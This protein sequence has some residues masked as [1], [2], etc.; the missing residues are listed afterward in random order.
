MREWVYTVSRYRLYI[1]LVLAVNIFDI[2][3]IGKIKL[4]IL[5]YTEFKKDF[6]NIIETE[7]ECSLMALLDKRELIRNVV[8][9]LPML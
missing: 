8:F 7:I 2:S 9:V 5:K 3:N 4:P 6:R 1:P